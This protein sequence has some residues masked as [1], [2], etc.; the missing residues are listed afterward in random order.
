MG[1][2]RLTHF[3]LFEELRIS[4]CN[5]G[6]QLTVRNILLDCSQYTEV[7][8]RT[9]INWNS[10][11]RDREATRKILEFLQI[12]DILNEVSLFLLLII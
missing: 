7:R 12:C 3:C 4:E 10:I 1:H 5:C 6:E 2:T 11:T 8:E 9:G